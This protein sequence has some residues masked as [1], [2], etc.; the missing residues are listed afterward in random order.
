MDLRGDGGQM[1]HGLESLAFKAQNH[2]S[3][4][5]DRRTLPEIM[6]L[7]VDRHSHP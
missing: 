5:L 3:V 6:N 1:S 2:S 4:L 7:V